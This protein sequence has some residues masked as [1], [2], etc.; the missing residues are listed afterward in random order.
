MSRPIP[1]LVCALALALAPSGCIRKTELPDPY[2][3]DIGDDDLVTDDDDTSPGDD[4][5]SPADDDATPVEDCH[6]PDIVADPDGT[7]AGPISLIGDVQ[8]SIDAGCDCHQ[9][10]NPS[11]VDLSPGHTW[12]SWVGQPSSADIEEI[13]VVPSVPESSVVLWKVLDCYSLFPHY[14]ATMPPNAPPLDLDE[15]TLY[16]NWIL[17][18]AEDN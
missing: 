18:G 2:D 7:L 3:D 9:Q 13:L 1:L 15:V 16:Y 5:T 6:H 10:G 17:Q 12:T 11:L 14:G 8:P 4:D